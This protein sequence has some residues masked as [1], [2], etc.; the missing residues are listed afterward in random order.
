MILSRRSIFAAPSLLVA[1][2]LPSWVLAEGSVSD[3]PIIGPSLFSLAGRGN[4][5]IYLK[6]IAPAA[7]EDG[8]RSLAVSGISGSVVSRMGSNAD[9]LDLDP[10]TLGRSFE[11]LV[12]AVGSSN[13]RPRVTRQQIHHKMAPLGQGRSM[14]VLLVG[15]S[16]TNRG[17]GMAA[18]DILQ[19]SGYRPNFIGTMLGGRVRGRRG[20]GA[21]GE[22]REGWAVAD[23]VYSVIDKD[24]TT[25]LGDNRDEIDAYLRM[26]KSQQL[27]VNPFLRVARPDDDI[28]MVRNRYRFDFAAYL[29]RFSLPVPDVVV[30][31]VGSNDV[32]EARARAPGIVADGLRI[33]CR[34]IRE[35]AP[36][37]KIGLWMPSIAATSAM[38]VRWPLHQPVVQTL[39]DFVRTFG[40]PL[41]EVV[42][43]WSHMDRD[44]GWLPDPQQGTDALSEGVIKDPIHPGTIGVDQMAEAIAAYVASTT[45]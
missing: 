39:I 2:A 31:G 41:I 12:E 4:L 7:A 42:P 6:S 22:G 3:L 27:R 24:V 9:R 11:L 21:M 32:S 19:S 38:R 5:S 37:A 36:M 35:A 25:V 28:V 18:R 14:N 16:I 45:V 34:A 15:D 33:M 10:R 30:L 29:R 23:F 13:G 20:P 26:P 40:D 43:V 17:L 1:G 8:I 44:R